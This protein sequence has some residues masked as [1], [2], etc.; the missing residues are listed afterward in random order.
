MKMQLSHEELRYNWKEAAKYY[1][2]ALNS[3]TDNSLSSAE[4]WERI[5]F[6]YSFAGRQSRNIDDFRRIINLAVEAYEKAADYF[7]KLP[8]LAGGGKSDL[9]RAKAQYNRS[10]L[11]IDSAEKDQTLTKSL[12]FAEIALKKFENSKNKI[13]AGKTY[14][15][16]SSC[17][18]DRLYIAQF[19]EEKLK[20]LQRSIE[21]SAS[22]ISLLSELNEKN[23]LLYAL[24]LASLENWYFANIVENEALRKESTKKSVDYATDAL[25][26]SKNIENSLSKGNALWAG[27]LVT[28][29]FTE[30]IDIA[31]TYAKELLHHS[32]DA[33]D[34][35]LRGIACY[36]IAFITDWLI[37]EEANPQ[38][39]KQRYE[40][41]IQY[42][43]QAIDNLQNV[44][45]DRAIAE[46]FLVYPQS[47]FSLAREFAVEHTEKLALSRKAVRLGEKGLEFAM[48]SGSPDVIGSSLHSLSKALHFYSQLESRTSE[49]LIL[50]ENALGYRK[51]YVRIVQEAFTS[52]YWVLGIGLFYAG[53]IEADLARLKE[54][55]EEKSC[56][57]REAVFDLK[58]GVS[59][60][61]KW[62]RS[63]PPSTVS[64][65]IAT[66]AGFENAFGT[67][68]KEKFT[69]SGD[70]TDLLEANG[71]FQ[72]AAEDFKKV[73]LPSRVAES[74]WK[75]AANLDVINDYEQSSVNFEKAFAGYKVAA[76]NIPDFSDLF[77]DYSNYM[78]AWS[79]IESAKLA[80]SNEEYE[81]A[82]NHY[83]NS[84][85]L[86]K[87]CKTWNYLSLNFYA[88]SI[89][90]QAED[91]SRNEKSLESIQFFESAIKFLGQ[92]KI[93]LENELLHIERKD[94]SDFVKRLIETSEARED[95][96]NGRILIEEAKILDQQ[97][98]HVKSSEKYGLAATVF[99]AVTKEFSESISKEAKPL[100]FL[101]QAW[102]KMTLAEAKNSPILYEDASNLF[103]KASEYASNQSAS[104][105]AL[106]HS[107]FCRALE[108]GTEFEITRNL[109]TYNETKKYMDA[110]SNCYLKA[111]FESFSEYAKATQRLFD[112]YVLM[113]NA[114]RETDPGKEAKFFLMAEKLLHVSLDSYS[115]AK[116]PEKVEQVQRLLQKVREE[117]ELAL[118]L[119]EVFHAHSIT[120]ST[121]SFTTINTSQEIAVGFERFERADIQAKI[122]L[123]LTKVAV[124]EDFTFSINVGNVGQ[125]PV[126]LV[127][128]ENILPIGFQLIEKPEDSTFQNMQLTMVGKR[129]EHLKTAEIKLKVR[130][131][132]TGAVE[133][134]PR[135]I[136][137]DDIGQQ[138][139]FSPEP[140]NL[141]VSD[142]ILAG[143]IPTGYKDLDNL[144]LGGIPEE[145]A[146]ILASPSNDEREL[147]VKRFVETGVKNN[148]ITF[149]I[150]AEVA[151][152][153]NLAKEY[154]TNF[155]LFVC[156]PRADVMIENLPNVYK[157]KGVESLTD[158]EIA[159][160]KSYRLLPALKSGPR[161]VCIDIISDVLLQ[162]RAIVARKWLSGILPDLRSKGF[163][164][165][166][167]V[168]PQMHPQEEVQAILG[169]FE[170]EIR[171]LERETPHGLE[172]V[173]RIRKL[174]NQK[175]MESELAVDRTKLES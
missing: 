146:V 16:I 174:Y 153:R 124:G 19:E 59:L 123:E 136:C 67:I 158:I 34:N 144:L 72:D 109:D 40:E 133:I 71:V 166:A 41:I 79:E 48:R 172:K 116:H 6:C 85:N 107:S 65:L 118:S 80:H 127:K 84:S 171:I 142:A 154:P 17:L 58:K 113:D 55:N 50:L 37:P 49:K 92:S 45:Q 103:K 164:N 29:F 89:L 173:L 168:N 4:H 13:D 137:V 94:E 141:Q 167:I 83:K 90:E 20:L 36:L 149:Y 161:R 101:C 53:Q 169:L 78:R 33:R 12:S 175:Y 157:L 91:A 129:L 145:Y 117:K 24:F 35:Y 61:Q 119:N 57:L 68:L 162:H 3:I 25:N 30:K 54:K 143:R 156:N 27:A 138:L 7:E 104:M 115:K 148:E 155:Y 87:Q 86:L 15:L 31:L 10:W 134:R 52:N 105:L 95:Y 70:R 93:A 132:K 151:G 159:L 88:W 75:I 64:S 26:L 76:Q 39:R 140:L 47:F 130:S 42:S 74:Y 96:C 63:L 150:T 66:V 38:K 114:K 77:T 98:N 69:L 108:A 99:N 170:G 97:G 102:Q 135:I 128:I 60:C 165:L 62:V 112:A 21:S 23:E 14:S 160:T 11:V 73:D 1:E 125:E 100:F 28:L 126:S 120:S 43:E 111:G 81:V 2:S 51:E 56:L 46:V 9:S 163:T 44:G 122:N 152:V 32:S 131:I 121:G 8:A 110:A 139:F 22:A 5:G 106:A 147:L 82:M 18:F